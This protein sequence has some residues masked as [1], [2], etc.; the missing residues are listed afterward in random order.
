[1]LGDMVVISAVT[2]TCGGNSSSHLY[3]SSFSQSFHNNL[4]HIPFGMVIKDLNPSM[5]KIQL[6]CSVLLVLDILIFANFRVTQP[7]NQDGKF[8]CL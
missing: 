7:L 5:S 6:L 1:M 4:L 2:F 8:K 3:P